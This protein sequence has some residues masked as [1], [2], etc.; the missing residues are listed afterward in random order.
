MFRDRHARRRRRDPARFRPAGADLDSAPDARPR[1]TPAV[2]S[3]RDRIP[4]RGWL[5]GNTFCRR[6]LSSLLGDG[7][8]GKT[9]LRIAQ[10]LACAT[11]RRLTGE[12]VF[13]RC[14][15]LLIS[16]ED[17]RDELRRRIRA[18]M[19]HH[20]IAPAD[21]KGW[22]ILAA[23]KGLKLMEKSSAGGE[24]PGRLADLLRAT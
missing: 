7:G 20:G 19:K 4:P 17:D 12:H 14:R 16:F 22:L 9:S 13:R 1:S 8:L 5:L 24:R 2:A 15:V 10:L 23:P 18:A 6:F 11:G 21:V 3:H